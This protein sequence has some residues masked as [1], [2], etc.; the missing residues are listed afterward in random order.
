M[1]EVLVNWDD[2][3]PTSAQW[4]LQSCI[5]R[6]GSRILDEYF[7]CQCLFS[8]LWNYVLNVAEVKMILES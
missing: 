2:D 4:M 1:I 5:R 8:R 6:R 7:Q 3:P